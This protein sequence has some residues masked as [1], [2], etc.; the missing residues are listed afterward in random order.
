VGI[1]S[2]ILIKCIR[3]KR[4]YQLLLVLFVFNGVEKLLTAY[5]DPIRVILGPERVYLLEM[6]IAYF[7]SQWLEN[8]QIAIREW[9]VSTLES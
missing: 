1:S 7:Q 2:F 6:F 5:Y 8:A 4:S 9:N 3:L